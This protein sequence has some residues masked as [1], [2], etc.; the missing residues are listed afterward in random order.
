MV[1][2]L[3]TPTQRITQI[4]KAFYS[5]Y[6][7]LAIGILCAFSWIM[8]MQTL[9]MFILSFIATYIL[10]TQEDMTPLLAPLI[11][12]CFCIHDPN[13]LDILKLICIGL[14]LICGAMY[15]LVEY[16]GN[17]GFG[18]MFI[19]FAILTIAMCLGGV[20]SPN[21]K[22]FGNSTMYIGSLG[23]FLMLLYVLFYKY[24]T[25]PEDYDLRLYLCLIFEVAAVTG[26]L[27][28][29]F[30]WIT[31]NKDV[32]S[33][34]FFGWGTYNQIGACF[35][36]GYPCFFYMMCRTNKVFPNLILA[37]VILVICLKSGCDGAKGLLCVFTPIL[38]LYTLRKMAGREKIILK[39]ICIT[40]LI[41][42]VLLGAYLIVNKPEFVK[43]V[44]SHFT[45]DNARTALY[46]IGLE[47]FLSY[48][49]FG[50]GLGQP[51][52]TGVTGGNF[53][54]TLIH[55]GATM[56]TVGLLVYIFYFVMRIRIINSDI[57]LFNAF[58]F[59][60]F[61]ILEIYGFADTCE[62]TPF[63]IMMEITLIVLFCDILHERKIDEPDLSVSQYNQELMRNRK[64]YKATF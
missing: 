16:R 59:F 51:L 39:R 58:M 60:S 34:A 46:A 47:D 31:E 6:Y 40:L 45:D 21:L 14:P 18:K 49:I 5:D 56:G 53:H 37:A 23:I 64:Y 24:I 4:N 38:L 36:I 29:V 61:V 10:F 35:L 63:P 25:P 57:K 54:C 55:V 3:D 13:K 20:F 7:P 15:H 9:C 32:Y 26:A 12:L 1:N 28:L 41:I 8:Q 52:A 11:L 50:V 48:P 17:N 22:Y 27:E 2:V 19:P 43:T 42:A 30:R 62:F 33:L 44:I